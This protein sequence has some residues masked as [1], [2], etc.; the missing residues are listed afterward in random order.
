MMLL[1]FSDFVKL[2]LPS[3]SE[4]VNKGWQIGVKSCSVFITQ[5]KNYRGN[6]QT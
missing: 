1:M 4:E 2:S 3:F 6:F 5:T